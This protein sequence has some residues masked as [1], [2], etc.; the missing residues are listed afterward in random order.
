LLSADLSAETACRAGEVLIALANP[1]DDVRGTADYRKLLIPRML[2]RAVR[3]ITAT[4]KKV[5]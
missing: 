3:E 1:V 5:A 4:R 2:V